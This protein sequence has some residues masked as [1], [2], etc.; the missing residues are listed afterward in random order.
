MR[1]GIEGTI[2]QGVHRCDRRRSRYVGLTKTALGHIVVAT[3]LNL[4][5]VAAWRA[6]APRSVTRPAACARLAGAAS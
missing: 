3:A 6:E 4:V 1:S 5:R 2:S